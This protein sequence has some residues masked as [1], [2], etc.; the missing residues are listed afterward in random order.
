MFRKIALIIATSA[1]VTLASGAG[2]AER[3][4]FNALGA[5]S[6]YEAARPQ[7]RTD[8]NATAA[9]EAGIRDCNAAAAGLK[10]YSYGVTESQVYRS[11]MARHGQ[12]E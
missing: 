8:V 6:P 1:A 7:I 12:V 5:F 11:C 2:A 3:P 10:Q 4:G 9:R